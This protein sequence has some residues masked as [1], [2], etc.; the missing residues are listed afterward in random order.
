MIKSEIMA[1]NRGKEHTT[2][3]ET[4]EMV[5]SVLKL[6]PQIKMIA[7]GMIT[8]GARG[9]AGKRFVT[10]VHMRSGAELIIT[11]QSVQKVAVHA[12]EETI[13][14]MVETLKTSKKLRNFEIKERERKPGI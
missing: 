9:K 11:G 1:K 2:L 8:V 5:V 4:A 7:P 3:T 12:D 14:R 10:V 6:M 13:A